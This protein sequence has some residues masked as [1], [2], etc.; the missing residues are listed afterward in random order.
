[1][2]TSFSGSGLVG[3]HLRHEEKPVLNQSTRTTPGMS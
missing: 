2:F 1:L 3:V